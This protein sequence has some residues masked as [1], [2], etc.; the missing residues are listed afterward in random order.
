MFGLYTICSDRPVFADID[1]DGDHDCFGL[2]ESSGLKFI[3]YQENTGTTENP[4]F[5]QA[6]ENPFGISQASSTSPV[7]VDAD[8]DGDLDLFGIAGGNEVGKVYYYEN[9]GSSASPSY[10]NFQLNPFGITESDLAFL[11]LGD[12]D[13]DNDHDGYGA[14][15]T[16]RQLILYLENEGSEDSS[17][18]KP[19]DQNPHNLLHDSVTNL[20]LYDIDED[21]D[22]DIFGSLL[23]DG[24]IF[25]QENIS[26]GT[27]ISYASKTLN[28]YGLNQKSSSAPSI[29]DLN[30]DGTIEVFFID[31]NNSSLVKQEITH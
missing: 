8:A 10:S 11:I 2:K 14:R 31:T 3:Y 18:Y 30:N 13:R 21:G 28:P 12:I 22:L 20:F 17:N 29:I 25:Y 15:R 6:V 4:L 7:L 16:D 26:S 1:N 23:D 27:Q 5:T 19:A 24:T 9:T